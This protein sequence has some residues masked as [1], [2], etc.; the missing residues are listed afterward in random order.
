MSDGSI[1]D[2]SEFIPDYP[3]VL[4]CGTFNAT[5]LYRT[6]PQENK[7]SCT[8]G[9]NGSIAMCISASASCT[10][11]P[12]NSASAIIEV[13]VTPAA[14]SIIAL[15]GLEFYEKAP[16]TYV[17]I[18][19]PSGQN[20][21]PKYYGIRIL[22]NGTQIF[23]QHD[24]PTGQAWNLQSYDFNDL[25]LFK[26]NGPTTFRIE[27]L[28]YC[29]IGNGAVVSAWDLDEIKVF[30]SCTP[31]LNSNLI[32]EGHVHN[33]DNIALPA[34]NMNLQNIRTSALT[35][36]LSNEEGLYRFDHLT[37]QTPYEISGS[38]NDDWLNGVN[39][40]DLLNIQK[41][42]LGKKLFNTLDQFIAADVNRSGTITVMDLLDLRKL[43]LGIYQELPT[44][45]SWRL[46]AMPMD[47][48]SLRIEDFKDKLW[49]PQLVDPVT[50][51]DFLAVKVGDVN[52][53]AIPAAIHPDI[54]SRSDNSVIFYLENQPLSIGQPD[55]LEVRA[56]A[57]GVLEG[58]QCEIELKNMHL[59]NIKSGAIP[60]GNDHY[61]IHENGRVRISW[62]D[63]KPVR[64]QRGE[65]L[66][67]F[68]VA[69]DGYKYESVKLAPSFAAQ[70][71]MDNSTYPLE[72]Q[73]Q[74]SI[75]S[76][77]KE[78]LDQVEIYPNPFSSSVAVKFTLQQDDQV[79]ISIF[80]TS[81]QLIYQAD[82]AFDAGE[83]TFEIGKAALPA[84]ETV[85]YCQLISKS[86]V[87]V[88]KLVRIR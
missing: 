10:Y 84:T 75:H 81:G 68:I 8:P 53:D 38:K 69:K 13:T 88:K 78:N 74:N 44:N 36:T 67:T 80:N 24:I 3:N 47:M 22:K 18:D 87:I 15:N 28:P 33:W 12:G 79:G 56:N 7:H 42:L 1:M 27:L 62:N 9:V 17:W 71:Y 11:Q 34:A 21:Y 35:T 83:H 59:I 45:S 19:G 16:P 61:V 39:T 5:N 48:S 86:Q 40:L 14:D 76:V 66:F 54:E 43:I 29:P 30:A 23:E 2:Y 70:V 41:H 32:I 4:P 73:F 77:L 31:K 50:K 85:L 63:V 52:H 46:G 49:L 57:D 37:G 60:I 51:V 20:N 25:P 82:Q 6:P 72:L 58:F 55:Q 26:V 64:Y 65:V